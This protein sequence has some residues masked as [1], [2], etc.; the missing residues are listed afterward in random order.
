MTWPRSRRRARIGAQGTEGKALASQL[1][2]SIE[3][4]G[5][6]RLWAAASLPLCS[7]EGA[8]LTLCPILLLFLPGARRP[9]DT[10]DSG[11]CYIWRPP[12]ASGSGLD[13]IFPIGRPG[14]GLRRQTRGLGVPSEASP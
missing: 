3:V 6:R 4:G 7:P 9:Q 12:Q 11:S 8:P 2:P 1:L 13:V 10:A 14:G 5:G